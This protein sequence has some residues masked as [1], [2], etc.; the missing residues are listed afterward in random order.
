MKQSQEERYLCEGFEH[1]HC[2]SLPTILHI[3]LLNILQIDYRNPEK[4]MLCKFLM[5][6]ILQNLG[7]VSLKLVYHILFATQHILWFLFPRTR[8]RAWRVLNSLTPVSDWDRISPHYVKIYTKSCRQVM[9]IEKN[10]SYKITNWS[11]TKVSKL[12]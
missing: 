12:T 7:S 1:L 5:L 3:W 10:I 4:R 9:R 8:T 6:K 11:D 2:S